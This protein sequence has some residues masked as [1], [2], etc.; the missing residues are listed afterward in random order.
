M[1]SVTHAPVFLQ[2]DGLQ[3]RKECDAL[4]ELKENLRLD[5]ER[6]M[7]SLRFEV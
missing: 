5:M 6:E 7:E 4:K 2:E 3:T 1:F